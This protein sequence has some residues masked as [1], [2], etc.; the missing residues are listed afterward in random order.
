MQQFM[1]LM[2]QGWS[3]QTVMLG[4]RGVVVVANLTFEP[5]V[6]QW[7]IECSE[8]YGDILDVTYTSHFE[9]IQKHTEYLM[10]K[11]LKELGALHVR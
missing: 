1:S 2:D 9:D 4:L 7:K 5:S 6:Q 8:M 3:F 10:T 11:C